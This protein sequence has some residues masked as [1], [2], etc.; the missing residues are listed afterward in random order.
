[1][2]CH[3][4]EPAQQSL[5]DCN[6]PNVCREKDRGTSCCHYVSLLASQI[7]RWR[8]RESN[9]RPEGGLSPKGTRR[10]FG[11]RLFALSPYPCRYLG[12]P[13]CQALSP[14]SGF[15]W[16]ACLLLFAP[17]ALFSG[18]AC[19]LSRTSTP[20]L[21]CPL[22]GEKTQQSNTTTVLFT[23]QA[24]PCPLRTGPALFV[25]SFRLRCKQPLIL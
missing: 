16:L 9:P 19:L 21:G 8:R 15:R 14:P 22:M 23:C 12:F 17:S 5:K 18:R 3:A 6:R 13:L 25:V 1:L 20:L 11:G 24:C 2:I 10:C 4:R 7:S